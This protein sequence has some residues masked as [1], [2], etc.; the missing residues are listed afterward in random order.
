VKTEYRGSCVSPQTVYEV[1]GDCV[2]FRQLLYMV[3]LMVAMK[4]TSWLVCWN[5]WGWIVLWPCR[6]WK[7]SFNW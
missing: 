3:Q 2:P 4:P 6:Y 7:T 5:I 1:C